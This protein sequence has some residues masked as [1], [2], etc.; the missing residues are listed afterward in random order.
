MWNRNSKDLP[1]NVENI[2]NDIIVPPLPELHIRVL[3]PKELAPKSL[4]LI[5]HPESW[6]KPHMIEGY[7]EARYYR[8]G[9]FRAVIMSERQ[10]EVAYLYRKASLDN[11]EKFVRTGDFR[12]IPEDCRFLRVVLCP[13]FSLFHREE[14]VEDKF[15]NW[16]NDNPPNNRRGDWVPFLDGWSFVGYPSGKFYGKQY[17]LR[18]FHN[19]TL[20]FNMDLDSD[21]DEKNYLNLN[22]M[23]K[24]FGIMTFPYAKM[25]FEFLKISG[26]V[27]IQV[28]LYNVKNLNAKFPSSE[29]YFEVA[30]VTPIATD[31]ITFVEEVSVSELWFN[32]DNVLRRVVN[33]LASAFGI[34]QK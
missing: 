30:G 3:S 32:S 23:R 7:Q 6:N 15:R 28:S 18:L 5:Y 26:P 13:R 9:N 25:A 11:L 24:V 27:L 20:C 10:V 19:G 17:E 29:R 31:S 34:W 12:G 1:M 2:L 14:M 21:I 4:L 22:E 33:R 16:L 8:R